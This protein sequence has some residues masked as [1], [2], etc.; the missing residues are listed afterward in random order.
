MF[1]GHVVTLLDAAVSLVNAL[2]DGARQGRPYTAP[3]GE[4]LPRAVHEALPPT[5]HRSA[6]EPEHATYLVRTAQQ[7][8]AVF[9][10]VDNNHIDQAAQLVNALLR[11]T[12]ARPQLDSVD[13]EPW[14]V[15]FH[16]SDDSLSVG[17]SAGCATALALAIGSTLAGRLGVCTA[18]HCDRVYVDGSRNA[19]RHFCS[20]A[21]RSRVKAAAF[22]AR[23]ASQN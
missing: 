8:R 11:T 3:R 7:M 23:K 14:Q 2:T 15:H 6:V 22:R 9:E 16:G 18:P 13:G 21:C 20:T 19:V 1:D 12:G 10:A 17:W 4:Q 5:P